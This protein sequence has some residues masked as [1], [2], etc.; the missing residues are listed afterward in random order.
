MPERTAMPAFRYEAI[1]PGGRERRGVVEA[2]TAR[3]ARDR[4]RADGFTPTAVA[5]AA[6]TRDALSGV[7]LD[8]A[9][10]AL[11]TR[12]LA[13]LVQ[14]GMPLDQAL[15]AVSEQA[16]N[17]RAAKIIGVVRTQVMA[18]EPLPSALA[19]FPR[20][21]STLYRGLVGA[22]TETG[23]LGE[24][25]ARLADYLD[26][27]FALRQKFAVALIYPALVMVVAAGVIAVLLVYVVPQVVSVYQQSRQILPLLT[28]ALIAT[29]DFFRVTGWY[30]VAALAAAAALIMWRWRSDSF[31]ARVHTWLLRVP[32][33][34]RLAASLDCA[35]YAS[36]LAILVGSGAPLLRS[37]AAA[38]D[39]VRLIPIAAASRRANTLVREGVPLSRAL[40]EQR[41][42]PPVLVHLVANGEESGALAPMLVRAA[43]ELEREA[44]RRLAWLAALIQPTLIV[45]MGAIVLVLV[46]AVMLPIVTMN[47]LV[48]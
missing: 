24:V 38:S 1:D 30:W 12:Q 2:E 9:T 4:L 40:R 27:R 45:A 32:G 28:R 35:R 10:T 37:L 44:E 39:V 21:F 8:A 33:A 3:A 29:S 31:R 19:R 11:V 13:T 25:L 43:Q 34:G 42:F 18:G 46:L 6:A 14:S 22:G 41:A 48:R 36:T 20:T 17:P 23:R 7:R 5:P 26:A 47:Q 16:D 15:A